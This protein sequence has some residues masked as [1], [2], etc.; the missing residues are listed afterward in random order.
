MTNKIIDGA[1]GIKKEV[2]TERFGRNLSRLYI[3]STNI[4]ILGGLQIALGDLVTYTDFRC[5][6]REV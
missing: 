5:F 4:N 1:T 3:Y 2:C 6:W